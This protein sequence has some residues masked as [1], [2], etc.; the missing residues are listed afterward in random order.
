MQLGCILTIFD[1]IT[2]ATLTIIWNGQFLVQNLQGSNTF[3]R[4]NQLQIVF[5]KSLFL[6][7]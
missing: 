2:V 7:P 4:F 3:A 1:N 5:K 6:L